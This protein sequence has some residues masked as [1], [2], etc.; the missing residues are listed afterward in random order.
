VTLAYAVP[1]SALAVGVMIG[2]GRWL[3]GSALIILV[4]Y[5]AKFWVLGYRPVEAALDRLSPEPARAARVS[6]AGAA[7]ALR[8]V[9]LPPLRTAVATAAAL[10]FLFAFHELTM[11]TIL[12]GPGSE[13]FAVV[14]LNHRDLGNVGVAAAL[15]IVLT[16]PVCLAAGLL[17]ALNRPGRALG[18]P[19]RPG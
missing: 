8:T 19:G 2:Y 12:Y 5:L 10:V 14:V 4:A 17:L 6:G 16:V 11:S 15:A 9:V 7:T 3:A 18:R 1:G 13:T